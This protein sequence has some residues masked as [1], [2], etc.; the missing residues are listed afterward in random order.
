M[1]FQL[2]RFKMTPVGSPLAE[3]VE[4]SEIEPILIDRQIW[5][6]LPNAGGREPP[7]KRIASARPFASRVGGRLSRRGRPAERARRACLALGQLKDAL[8]DYADPGVEQQCVE[9]RGARRNH[10]PGRRGPRLRA[11]GHVE[12]PA[13]L[14]TNR[15]S[16]IDS[17]AR[18]EAAEE[19]ATMPAAL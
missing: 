5:L 17:V 7:S 9:R 11:H 12:R 19:R 15:L 6:T 18:R 16:S 4:L 10:H 1:S 3:L 13:V 2:D 8:A 14:L